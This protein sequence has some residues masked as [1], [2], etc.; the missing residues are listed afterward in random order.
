[1]RNNSRAPC[2][3]SLIDKKERHR[4][5][6]KSLLADSERDREISRCSK[7]KKVQISKE[8]NGH[9][10][11][12]DAKTRLFVMDGQDEEEKIKAYWRKRRNVQ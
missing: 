2:I 6:D 11:T 4:I 8:S 7:A 1:M 5:N 9:F 12:I 3:Q 10:V